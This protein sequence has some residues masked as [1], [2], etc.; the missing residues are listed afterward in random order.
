MGKLQWRIN[1]EAL[2]CHGNDAL[3]NGGLRHC[4]EQSTLH[5][6]M[7]AESIEVMS[8]LCCCFCAKNN[9]QK[10]RHQQTERNIANILW[11]CRRNYTRHAHAH[12]AFHLSLTR[13]GVHRQYRNRGAASSR[14]PIVRRHLESREIRAV[15]RAVA[16][17]GRR[18][19]M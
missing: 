4:H 14:S 13:R 19:V 16:K 6:E 10:W 15:V 1:S 5:C 9:Q 7:A 2:G 12:A 11:Y 17:W 3:F 8:T 18:Y